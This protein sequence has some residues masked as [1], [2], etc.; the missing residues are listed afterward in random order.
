MPN[1]LKDRIT[2]ICH[3]YDALMGSMVGSRGEATATS[4]GG[5]ANGG[6]SQAGGG[7]PG[8]GSSPR[9]PHQQQQPGSDNGEDHLE[10]LTAAGKSGI[11]NDTSVAPVD[12]DAPV[13]P[14]NRGGAYP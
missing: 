9:P 10:A 2:K 4:T 6:G 7:G 1:D 5:E 11:D 13:A 14:I 12:D 8:Q 3:D